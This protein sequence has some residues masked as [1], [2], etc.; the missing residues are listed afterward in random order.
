MLDPVTKIKKM[1]RKL[2]VVNQHSL[3]LNFLTVSMNNFGA[4]NL[5]VLIEFVRSWKLDQ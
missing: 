1:Q 4:R 2:F 5:L 3:Y